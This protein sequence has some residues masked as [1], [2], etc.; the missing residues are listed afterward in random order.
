MNFIEKIK[1]MEN[2]RLIALVCRDHVNF[3]YIQYFFRNPKKKVVKINLKVKRGEKAPSI[4]SYFPSAVFHEQEIHEGF[5]VIF[6]GN[7]K[8]DLL[9]LS[10]EQNELKPMRRDAK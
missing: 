10:E 8:P 7:E 6:E 4:V 3:F 5:G 9:F 1:K 2:S